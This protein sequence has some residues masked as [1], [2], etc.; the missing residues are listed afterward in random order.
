MG[1]VTL[2]TGYDG[3]VISILDIS[4]SG[5]LFEAEE[6]IDSGSPIVVELGETT[7]HQARIVWKTGKFHGAEFEHRLDARGL[8]RLLASSAVVWPNCEDQGALPARGL[9]TAPTTQ[10]V[11][12]TNVGP[13]EKLPFA[14]RLRI[15]TGITFGLWVFIGS[16][17]RLA[18]A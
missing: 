5:V 7:A 11:A 8:Q 3:S 4:S 14:K 18:A 2:G 9:D 6:T 16:I 12:C 13:E 10:E 15:I 1:K 17:I